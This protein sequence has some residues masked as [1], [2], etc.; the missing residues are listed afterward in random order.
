LTNIVYKEL[1]Y[2]KTR[3]ACYENT[4]KFLR[5]IEIE[6]FS[7]DEIEIKKLILD[8]LKEKVLREKVTSVFIDVEL[9]KNNVKKI[10]SF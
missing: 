1:C 8:R 10:Q 3:E 9:S 4:L 6:N 5:I 2:I 7:K